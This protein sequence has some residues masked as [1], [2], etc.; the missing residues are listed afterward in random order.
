[1]AVLSGL[2]PRVKGSGR[3]ICHFCQSLPVLLR[4]FRCTCCRPRVLGHGAGHGQ[5]TRG[6]AIRLYRKGKGRK[7][8]RERDLQLGPVA[9]LRKP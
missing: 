2:W 5:V 4:R 7:G 3:E 8:E 9:G 1:M 6:E